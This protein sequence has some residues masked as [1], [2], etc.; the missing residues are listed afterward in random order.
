MMHFLTS[1]A[2][3]AGLTADDFHRIY[4]EKHKINHKRQDEGYSKD[5]KN[6]DD[7]RNIV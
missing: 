3:S 4:T 2:L 5:S 7:N 6:E 1:L